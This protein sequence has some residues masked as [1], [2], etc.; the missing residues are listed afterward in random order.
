[1][2]FWNCAYQLINSLLKSLPVSSTQTIIPSTR[3]LQILFSLGSTSPTLWQK[4]KIWISY[5]IPFI[6]FISRINSLIANPSL[7]VAIVNLFTLELFFISN[8]GIRDLASSRIVNWIGKIKECFIPSSGKKSALAISP[9]IVD[10][11]IHP[12]SPFFSLFSSESVSLEIV[13][14]IIGNVSGGVGD[15]LFVASLEKLRSIAVG[16]SGERRLFAIKAIA[17]CGKRGI[18]IGDGDSRLF[19]FFM[20]VD[21]L[22]ERDELSEFY[23]SLFVQYASLC[24]RFDHLLLNI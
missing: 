7:Q 23:D 6:K 16:G 21:L 1:L 9:G 8:S 20:L 18:S 5:A 3:L 12:A 11:F 22:D 24:K 15:G 10:S 2:I 13:S 17:E 14:S 4:E 19:A